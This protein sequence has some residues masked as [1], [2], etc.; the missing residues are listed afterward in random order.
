MAPN[1]GLTRMITNSINNPRVFHLA[2]HTGSDTGK[3]FGLHTFPRS[4]LR[5]LEGSPTSKWL[6]PLAL[7]PSGGTTSDARGALPKNFS[8]R[9][10]AHRDSIYNSEVTKAA[11]LIPSAPAAARKAN[12]DA[13]IY[14]HPIP[15]ILEVVF[16]TYQA[17]LDS[18]PEEPTPLTLPAL[19]GCFFHPEDMEDDSAQQQNE[20]AAAEENPGYHTP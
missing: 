7:P 15:P 6:V 11:A 8:I 9:F 17:A 10:G 5:Q 1:S 19:K 18:L 2:L 4:I 20:G 14:R 13:L 12:A 16:P 3:R